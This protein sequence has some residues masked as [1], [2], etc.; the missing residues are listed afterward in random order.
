MIVGDSSNI[1]NANTKH[2]NDKWDN[3]NSNIAAITTANR[4]NILME[5]DM[6]TASLAWGFGLGYWRMKNEIKRTMTWKLQ[7]R[8]YI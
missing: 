3:D 1:G 5:H 4:M 8:G 6:D 2:I 7:R